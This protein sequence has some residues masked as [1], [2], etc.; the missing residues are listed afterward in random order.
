MAI[1]TATRAAATRADPR[2]SRLV[3]RDA[4]ANDA[5]VYAVETTGVY[6]R[7]ACPARLA[8]PEHVRFF[9]SAAAAARAGYRPCKRC[10]PDAPPRA[11]TQAQIVAEACRILTEAEETP[12]LG[13]LARRFGYSPSHFQRMFKSITGMTPRAYA[14]A[15]RAARMRQML[16]T[17]RTVTEALYEA[18]YGSSGRF[19][20]HADA[21]LGMTPRR[22]RSGGAGAEIRFATGA[23]SLGAVLVARTERGI[24][25]IALGDDAE[26]LTQNFRRRFPAAASVTGDPVFAALVAQVIALVEAPGSADDLPLDMR[27]T[28][29]QHRVW[30]AL[31][32][33]PPGETLTY[34]ELAARI[35]APTAIRAVARACATNDLAVAIPC[36]R[37]VRRDGDLAGYR[38]GLA[39]KQALLDRERGE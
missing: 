38:W 25:A 8:K 5:F 36:H 11:A 14:A 4:S 17:T 23:S 16:E 20:A 37:V 22:Y 21:A 1:G 31:R 30:D 2:W 19:H 35:G 34:T 29:F 26:A 24:C 10:T 33:I 6:C 7:P 13:D 27:G 18:G 39:R 15:D 12:S 32:R 9:L 3:A 28:V